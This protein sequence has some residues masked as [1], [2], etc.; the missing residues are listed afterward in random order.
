MG[1]KRYLLLALILFFGCETL[2]AQCA[3]GASLSVPLPGLDDPT[4]LFQFAYPCYFYKYSASGTVIQTNIRPTYISE[5]DGFHMVSKTLE[6]VDYGGT[7]PTSGTQVV[8][9]CDYVENSGTLDQRAYYAARILTITSSEVIGTTIAMVEVPPVN[10]SAVGDTVTIS[11]SAVPSNAAVA[12][13]RVVRSADG[14][15]NWVTVGDTTDTSKQDE[16]GAGTWYY[17]LQ[18]RYAGSPVTYLSSH[19]LVA[20]ITIAGE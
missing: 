10:V 15:S 2:Y 9:V 16:P 19:G 12:G 4:N 18:I 11:W 7:C 5:T 8:A 20:S 1:Y 6:S 3:L 13:Y 14:L 17:A